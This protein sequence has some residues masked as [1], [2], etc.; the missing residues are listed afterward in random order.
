MADIDLLNLL[1][2]LS[3]YRREIIRS[4]DTGIL[5]LPIN[6]TQ[7][8]VLMA[9]LKI[10]DLSMKELSA[11]VGLEKSS[12]TRVIDSLIEGGFVVRTYDVQDRRKINCTLTKKGLVQAN[13][14]DRLMMEHI[15]NCFQDLSQG[16]KEILINNLTCA[17][18]TLSKYFK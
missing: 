17:V 4:L 13:K 18:K 12:L 11:Q 6:T 5:R 14:I 3:A 2:T 8:R 7:E 1:D 9:I 16:E 10:P 15:E